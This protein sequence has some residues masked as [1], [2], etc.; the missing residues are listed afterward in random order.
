MIRE[1]SRHRGIK[2]ARQ[3][4]ESDGFK[5]EPDGFKGESGEFK[6]EPD[7]FKGE[8]AGFKLEPDEFKLEFVKFKGEMAGNRGGN[9][10]NMGGSFAR[11]SAFPVIMGNFRILTQTNM[12]NG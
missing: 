5:P 4:G 2:A 3:G 10:R 12:C 6:P 7:E 11:M 1:T 9:G 8:L